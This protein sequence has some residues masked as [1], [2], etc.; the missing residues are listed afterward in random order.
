MRGEPKGGR[1]ERAG[2]PDW[3]AGLAKAYRGRE[4]WNCKKI[5]AEHP[6]GF[7]FD[8]GGPAGSEVAIV[9]AINGAT[10]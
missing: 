3:K 7:A 10:D 5:V 6:L 4:N 2:G 1:S 9:L 8:L